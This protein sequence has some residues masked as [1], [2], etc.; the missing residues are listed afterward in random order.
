MRVCPLIE[1]LGGV[2]VLQ[3]LKA[4]RLPAHAWPAQSTMVMLLCASAASNADDNG[5]EDGA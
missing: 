2:G 1:A 4:V 3:L 5:D